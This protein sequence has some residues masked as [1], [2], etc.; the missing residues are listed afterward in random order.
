MPERFLG[1]QRPQPYTYLPF[2][3]GPRIC[4]GASFG[5][6]EAILCLASLAQ[7]FRVRIDPGARVEPHCRLTLR[8]KYGLPVVLERRD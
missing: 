8:P 6:V 7:R 2:S 3:A 4:T 5:L 1:E